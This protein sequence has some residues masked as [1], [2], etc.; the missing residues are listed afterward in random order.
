MVEVCRYGQALGQDV[1]CREVQ[2]YGVCSAGRLGV[3][4]LD[5]ADKGLIVLERRVGVEG[6]VVGHTLL[7]TL[8]LEYGIEAHYLITQ[9]YGDAAG[10]G[11]YDL[12]GGRI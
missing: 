2:I 5:A 3:G 4:A 10:L 12:S 11:L 1:G 8:H 6:E 7:R 9:A